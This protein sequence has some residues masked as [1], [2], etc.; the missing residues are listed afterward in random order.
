MRYLAVVLAL[1]LAGCVTVNVQLDCDTMTR[2]A[3][4]SVE[5][6]WSD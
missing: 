2:E 1:I 5:E 4:K 6:T 3:G